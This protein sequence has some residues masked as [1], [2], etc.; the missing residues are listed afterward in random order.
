MAKIERNCRECGSDIPVSASGRP[1]TRCSS[2]DCDTRWLAEGQ[3]YWCPGPP[4]PGSELCDSWDDRSVA[5]SEGERKKHADW[6]NMELIA[7]DRDGTKWVRLRP[8]DWDGRALWF[9]ASWVGSVPSN[10]PCVYG[11]PG[12]TAT[13]RPNKEGS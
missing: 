12:A 11:S 8:Q 9:A 13:Y 6:V 2:R 7:T 10:K 3:I 1:K 4:S 5:N